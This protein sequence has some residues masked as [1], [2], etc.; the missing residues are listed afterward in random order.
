M[1][2]YDEKGRPFTRDSKR[3]GDYGVKT[4]SPTTSAA[5]LGA[6]VAANKASRPKLPRRT[7]FESDEA[8]SKAYRAYREASLGD[9]DN[10]AQKKA[11]SRMK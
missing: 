9:V 10:V 2:D 6:R 5:G 3:E 11:L 8:Y 4:A 7:D 1:T